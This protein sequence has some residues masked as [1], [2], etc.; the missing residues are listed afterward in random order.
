MKETNLKQQYTE[1]VQQHGILLEQQQKNPTP[2]NKQTNY[3]GGKGKKK[4]CG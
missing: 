2:Q 4:S 1:W 3:R